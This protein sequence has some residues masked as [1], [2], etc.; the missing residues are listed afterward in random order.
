MSDPSIISCQYELDAFSAISYTIKFARQLTNVVCGS[1]NVFL[2]VID[3]G[4][5]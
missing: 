2:G 4:Y 5:A 3:I 1:S